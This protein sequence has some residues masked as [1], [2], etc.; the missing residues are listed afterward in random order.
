MR[1]KCKIYN[2]TNGKTINRTMSIDAIK[3]LEQDRKY[4]ILE[5]RLTK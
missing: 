3:K 2:K 4:Q 1:F 5:M